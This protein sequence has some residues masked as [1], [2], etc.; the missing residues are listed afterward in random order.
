MTCFGLF[1]RRLV[2]GV[3]IGTVMEAVRL[4][5]RLP[6]LLLLTLRTGSLFAVAAIALFSQAPL[7]FG[8]AA[9]I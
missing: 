7:P 5:R 9:A 4:I 3:G 1:R 6:G 2:A 8:G